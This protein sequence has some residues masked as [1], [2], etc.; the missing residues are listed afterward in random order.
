V[1]REPG[2]DRLQGFIAS[3]ANLASDEARKAKLLY[4]RNE[5]AGYEAELEHSK[6][7]GLLQLAFAVIP[8]FWPV[9]YVQ[10]RA[11]ITDARM[12]LRRIQNALEVWRTELGDDGLAL[13]GELE[14]LRPGEPRLIPFLKPKAAPPRLTGG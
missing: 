2:V 10:R 5:I 3:I 1:Y 7:F 14:R 12:K 13:E 11:M 6:H 9:L 4:V 8:F